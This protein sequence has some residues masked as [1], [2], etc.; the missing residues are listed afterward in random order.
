MAFESSWWEFQTKLFSVWDY[1][2]PEECIVCPQSPWEGL[3]DCDVTLCG[4]C[5]PCSAELFVGDFHLVFGGFFGSFTL[6][7]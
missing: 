4:P 7:G 1:V 6:S 2:F 5:G 3:S